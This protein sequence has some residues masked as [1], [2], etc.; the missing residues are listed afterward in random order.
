MWYKHRWDWRKRP[1]L[2]GVKEVRIVEVGRP[3][4]ACNLVVS[5]NRHLE[6]SITGQEPKG[7]QHKKHQ[8]RFVGTYNTEDLV[9]PYNKRRLTASDSS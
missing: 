8:G 5:A 2:F 4:S 3:Q 1:K 9:R 7:K 6:I